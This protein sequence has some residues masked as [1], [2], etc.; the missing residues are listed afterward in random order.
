MFVGGVLQKEVRVERIRVVNFLLMKPSNRSRA[1]H[2]DGLMM[3][4]SIFEAEKKEP[5][6][7]SSIFSDFSW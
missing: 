6:C 5:S 1:R 7:S 2:S 4:S 3:F